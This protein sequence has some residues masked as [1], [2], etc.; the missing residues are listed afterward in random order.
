MRVDVFHH[1][2]RLSLGYYAEH[3][4]GD[5][6][7]RITNDTET[8]QQAFSFALVNVLSGALLLVWIGYNMFSDSVPFALLSL[9]VVPLMVVV[10]VW[11]SSQARKAYPPLTPGDGQRQRRT[12]G[13]HLG[14][15]RGA[16]LQPGR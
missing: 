8:I 10:T 2:H 15:A 9:V 12:A 4:A 3:E 14:G 11:F 7:S 13:E 6:M 1:L 5:L 16:G